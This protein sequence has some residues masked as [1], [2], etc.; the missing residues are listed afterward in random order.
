M[1]SAD[2]STIKI[3]GLTGIGVFAGFGQLQQTF[4]L[5]DDIIIGIIYNSA[6]SSPTRKIC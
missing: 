5:A 4:I 3:D 6:N 1:K 2:T